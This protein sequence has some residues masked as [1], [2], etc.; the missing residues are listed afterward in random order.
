MSARDFSHREAL[1]SRFSH[2]GFAFHLLERVG[3][4]ALFEKSKNGRDFY[5]VVIIQQLPARTIFGRAYP[6]REAMPPSESWGTHGWSLATLERA[7]EKFCEILQS[8]HEA[9]FSPGRTAVR[10]FSRSEGISVATTG[11]ERVSADTSISGR[12]SSSAGRKAKGNPAKKEPAADTAG[13]L[14]QGTNFG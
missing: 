2:D 12:S 3:D 10:A 8:R 4:V 5:E 1:A 11:H 9:S 6:P 13:S 7:S 14:R